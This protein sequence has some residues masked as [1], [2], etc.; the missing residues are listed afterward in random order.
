MK[1]K[2]KCFHEEEFKAY[3]MTELSYLENN[4]ISFKCPACG[5]ETLLFMEFE[6]V[7]KE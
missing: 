6:E 7:K 2:L 4:S 5:K 1:I 3:D